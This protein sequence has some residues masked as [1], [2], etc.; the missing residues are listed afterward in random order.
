[1]EVWFDDIVIATEYIGP[2]H[3]KPKNGKKIAVPSRSA[4]LTPGL[5]I[6]EPGDVAY[7]QNFEEG[8]GGF[9][10]GDVTDGGT[11]AMP[12]TSAIRSASPVRRLRRGWAVRVNAP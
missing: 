12:L 1:M 9:K 10:G 3:G 7:S 2:I 6:A 5:L 4:L 8:P 11:D